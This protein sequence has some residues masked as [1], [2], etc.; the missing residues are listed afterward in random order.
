MGPVTLR[1]LPNRDSGMVLQHW[2]GF[3]F[4]LGYAD[5][6]DMLLTI[7]SKESILLER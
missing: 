5:L 4:F 2:T 6:G 1:P 3:A 7:E